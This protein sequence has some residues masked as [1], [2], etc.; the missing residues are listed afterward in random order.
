VGLQLH[1]SPEI[2]PDGNAT[3]S[4]SQRLLYLSRVALMVDLDGRITD[5]DR[6]PSVDGPPLKRPRGRVAFTAEDDR[7][8][9]DWVARAEAEGLK[10]SGISK[11][12]EDLARIVSGSSLLAFPPS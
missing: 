5:H 11:V 10:I 12:F 2:Q 7:L 1:G 9:A 3:K 8:L 6:L 4:N